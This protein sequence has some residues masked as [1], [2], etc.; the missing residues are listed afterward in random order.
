MSAEIWHIVSQFVSQSVSC[1]LRKVD[2]IAG[3]R[4]LAK[5]DEGGARCAADDCWHN[6]KSSNGP[7]EA[8]CKRRRVERG[9][10]EGGRGVREVR[11]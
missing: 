3:E 7:E 5:E 10:G 8:K 11:V 9:T 1:F 2:C 6:K 4:M